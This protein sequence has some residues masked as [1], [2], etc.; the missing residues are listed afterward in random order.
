LVLKP[1]SGFSK[2]WSETLGNSL[3]NGTIPGIFVTWF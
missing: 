1:G 2:S 3:T